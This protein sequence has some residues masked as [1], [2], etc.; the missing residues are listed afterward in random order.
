MASV[1]DPIVTM[2]FAQG[3]FE[4]S[5]SHIFIPSS[6]LSMSDLPA[7][8][9]EGLKGMAMLRSKILG[10]GA[11]IVGVKASF[12]QAW[13]DSVW[14]G[15]SGPGNVVNGGI[16]AGDATIQKDPS[17][18]G[19]DSPESVTVM[20]LRMGANYQRLTYLGGLPKIYQTPPK[21]VT[22]DANFN[23]NW[24]AYGIYLKSPS[25]SIPGTWGAAVQTKNTDNPPTPN[26]NSIVL[27]NTQPQTATFG[28]GLHGTGG[29]DPY[30]GC[31]VRILGVKTQSGLGRTVLNGVYPTTTV[32]TNGKTF[33]VTLRKSGVPANAVLDFSQAYYWVIQ[34]KSMSYTDYGFDRY[35][36]RKR[37]NEQG[38]P[39]GRKSKPAGV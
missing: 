15:T 3:K 28:Y 30:F 26:I 34:T 32:D 7:V 17:V 21:S 27:S 10:A 37:G 25:L 39:V 16:V 8:A 36:H 6:P 4:W 29:I 11:S 19:C 20:R 14:L 12:G 33:T 2:Y 35:T 31:T 1:P 24:K 38:G 23:T 13:R 9:N 18:Y 5:E 22:W